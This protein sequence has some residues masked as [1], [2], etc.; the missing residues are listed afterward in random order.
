MNRKFHA[1]LQCVIKKDSWT[2]MIS[3]RDIRRFVSFFP[4]VKIATTTIPLTFFDF[5]TDVYSIVIYA[6]SPA[7]VVRAAA[8]L[9]GKFGRSRVMRVLWGKITA[10]LK[11]YTMNGRRVRYFCIERCTVHNFSEISEK[12][13]IFCV[14]S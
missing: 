2:K 10:K 8:A 4:A 11:Q 13:V 12:S 5:F 3:N 6:G 9:L 7:A 14:I 1:I